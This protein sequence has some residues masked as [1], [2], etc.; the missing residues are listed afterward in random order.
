M[1]GGRFLFWLLALFLT[2]GSGIQVALSAH[3]ARGLHAGLEAAQRS[4]DESVAMQSRLLVERAAL[5][6]YQNVERTAE[7]ELHMQFPTAVEQVNQ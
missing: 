1:S 4:H 5:A 3:E 7:E 2:V 6:A